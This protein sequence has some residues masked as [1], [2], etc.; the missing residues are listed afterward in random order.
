MNTDELT[1]RVGMIIAA[2]AFILIPGRWA[3]V[4]I[5]ERFA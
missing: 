2:I 5:W 1:A 3:F 4:Q